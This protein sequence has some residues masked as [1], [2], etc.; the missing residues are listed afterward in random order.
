MGVRPRLRV[1]VRVR[2]RVGVVMRLQLR[3]GVAVGGRSAHRPNDPDTPS[4]S[5]H[6]V[7]LTPLLLQYSSCRII[8]P[9]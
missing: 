2:V 9:S 4:L 6:L 8:T 3:L 1:R 7:P 5:S